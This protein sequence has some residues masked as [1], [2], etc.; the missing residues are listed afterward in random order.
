[1][2]LD[3]PRAIGRLYQPEFRDLDTRRLPSAP[4][5]F[6]RSEAPVPMT[7]IPSAELHASRLRAMAALPIIDQSVA[8]WLEELATLIEETTPQGEQS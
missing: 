6:E 5:R 2:N 4:P 7:R 8:H 1:M 3:E